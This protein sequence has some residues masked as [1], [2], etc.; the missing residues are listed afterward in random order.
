[1]ANAVYVAAKDLFLTGQL[2]WLTDDFKVCLVSAS[3]TPN[4]SAH[5]F[6]NDV[7]G[8]VATSGLLTGKTVTSG[9]VDASNITLPAV[10]GSQVVALV[11]FRDTG[12]PA[13]SN[14]IAFVDTATNLPLT[15]NGGPVD[16]VW[17][18]TN[19]VFNLT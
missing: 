18:L 5:D 11:V 17:D 13:T 16:V 15:P 3:Y 2:N 1:M 4:L 12:N 7:S 19:G 8:I 6:L 14:L 10:T 9:I